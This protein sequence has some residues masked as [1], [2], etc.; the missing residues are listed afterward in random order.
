MTS[1]VKSGRVAV[2]ALL[3]VV[4][5]AC[6]GDDGDEGSSGTTDGPDSTKPTDTEGAYAPEPLDEPATLTFSTSGPYEFIFPVHLA[7][8][9]GE[10]AKEDLTVEIV[11]VPANAQ[12]A[13]LAAGDADI[14][15]IGASAAAMNAV[16]QG[17]ELNFFQNTHDAPSEGTTEGIWVRKDLLADDGTLDPDQVDGM[18]VVLGTQGQASPT[19]YVAREMVE[20]VGKSVDDIEVTV[21]EPNADS[22]VALENGAV[23]AAHLLSPFSDDPGLTDCCALV[24]ETIAAGKYAALKADLE[25]RPEVYEAFTRALIRTQRGYLQG[26]YHQDPDVAAILAEFTGAPI[27]TVEAAQTW[28]GFGDEARNDDEL[29]IALQDMWLD[30]GEILSYDEPLAIEDMSTQTIVEAVNGS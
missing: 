4:L 30:F 23:D 9:K 18:K 6:G 29:V 15:G 12:L 24:Q 7:I 16:D 19:I 25:D 27:E 21:L 22:L 10:F 3:L 11:T 13:G 8:E 17:I 2:L 14:V 20:A 1:R 5:A 28:Y 26:N